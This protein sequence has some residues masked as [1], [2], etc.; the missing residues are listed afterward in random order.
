MGGPQAVSGL[1]R[2]IATAE[3]VRITGF[4]RPYLVELENRGIIKKEK[5]GHWAY[6]ETVT[7][8]ILNLRESNKRREGSP[9]SQLAAMRAAEI[10]QRM[11]IRSGAL[12]TMEAATTLVARWAGSVRAELGGVAV[13]CTRDLPLRRKIENEINEALSRVCDTIESQGGE[14]GLSDPLGIEKE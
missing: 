2:E 9:V 10:R 5:R 7:A 1:L 3:L 4:S 11:D 12:I 13:R 6:P 8:I 14:A